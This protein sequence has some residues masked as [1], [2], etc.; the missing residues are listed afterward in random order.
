M[1][2]NRR[3][4]LARHADINLVAARG[5]TKPRGR[6]PHQPHEGKAA[7]QPKAYTMTADEF[8]QWLTRMGITKADAA[9]ALGVT[10]QA[11]TEY[12]HNRSRITPTMQR[13]M[14]A[15]ERLQRID[16]LSAVRRLARQQRAAASQSRQPQPSDP[17]NP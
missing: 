9:R 13:L 4:R 15:L 11:V 5:V 16:R 12:S 6:L 8:N 10:P 17:A 14:Q 1:H 7:Q 2:R 3:L